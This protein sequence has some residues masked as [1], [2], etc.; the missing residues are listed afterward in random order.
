MTNDPSPVTLIAGQPATP[1]QRRHKPSVRADKAA[2]QRL[3]SIKPLGRITAMLLLRGLGGSVR[4]SIAR[5]GDLRLAGTC[6][7]EDV[8]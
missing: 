8:P 2:D 4:G 5:T 3:R 7:R 6:Y 1:G